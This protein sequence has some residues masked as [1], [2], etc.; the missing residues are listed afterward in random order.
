[1]NTRVL[2]R[3]S[4][5]ALAFL[6]LVLPVQAGAPGT[7]SAVEL[8]L[9]VGPRAIAM[10]EAYGA[11]SNDILSLYWNPAGLRQLG[12]V[13][14]MAQYTDFIDTITYNYFAIGMPVGKKAAAGLGYKMV[15]SGE[16]EEISE[17]GLPTGAKIG[18]SY[19]EVDLGFAYKLRHNVDIGLT[20]KYLSEK[21]ESSEAKSA[22]TLAADIGVSYR[23][24]VRNLT[25]AL[26]FQNLGTGLKYGPEAEK[27]P[28]NIKVGSAYKMFENNFTAAF[29]LN[30]PNDNKPVA[31]LG[32]EYWYKDRLAGRF[33]YRYQGGLDWNANDAGGMGG[34][35]LGVGLKIRTKGKVLG[36]DYAWSTQGYLGTVHRI[37]LNLYL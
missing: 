28:T 15:S 37:A 9:P 27:L 3:G 32:G 10:G 13:H 14:F 29:D 18:L 16:E 12:G 6:S 11:V 8:Q 5:L 34:L 22:S 17:L 31:S 20:A 36:V 35:Y 19:M 24:S 21:L 1:M 4:I 30:F 7:T 33:G 2:S 25:L 23:P 26:V